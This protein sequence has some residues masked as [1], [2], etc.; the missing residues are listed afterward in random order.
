MTPSRR[1]ALNA[2]PLS[3]TCEPN[4]GPQTLPHEVHGAGPDVEMQD[5]QQGTAHGHRKGSEYDLYA[6]IHHVGALG[7]GHYVASVR[8]WNTD[9]CE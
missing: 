7:G 8:D 9:T 1:I 5:L 4:G 3:Q 2:V 6:V